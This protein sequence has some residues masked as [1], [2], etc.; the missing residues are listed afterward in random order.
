LLAS[1]SVVSLSRVSSIHSTCDLDSH[2]D[3]SCAGSNFI[4]LEDPVRFATVYPYSSELPALQKIPKTFAGIAWVNPATG[5]LYFLIL[6]E[7]LFFGDRLNHSLLCP[8]Q[9]WSN[10][11]TVHDTPM[12]FDQHSTHSI[13]NPA[14]GISMDLKCAVSYFDSYAPMLEEAM[15]VPV[16]FLPNWEQT[17]AEF[18]NQHCVV[19]IM[20][21]SKRPRD[22]VSQFFLP[23]HPAFPTEMLNHLELHQRMI[24]CVNFHPGELSDAMEEIENNVYPL[25]ML[26]KFIS[27]L[28][29]EQR[30]SVL[31]PELL[32]KH[33]GIGLNTA[34]TTLENTTQADI[35]NV[36]VPSERKVRKKAPWLSYPSI[37]SDFYTDQIFSKSL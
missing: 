15:D 21:V 17:H 13:Y 33:W 20:H 4:Q 19:T 6:N 25:G 27:S 23:D 30:K 11:L 14:S 31:S 3:T 35:H 34:K 16:I 8:N 29:T 9:L 5:Q 1:F 36:F 26:R 24:T 10:G 32:A 37:K 12:M 28:S 22:L 7:C 18:S 2:A